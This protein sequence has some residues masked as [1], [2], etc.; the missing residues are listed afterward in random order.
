MG[1]WIKGVDMSIYVEDLS[2]VYLSNI[3][4][5]NVKDYIKNF[6]IKKRVQAV[7]NLNFKIAQGE[8][9]GFIGPNGAGKSTTIKM[10]S[11]ILVPTSGKIVINGLIPFKDRKKYVKDIGVVFGQRSQ[12]WWDIPAIDSFELLKSIYKVDMKEYKSN[13]ETLGELLNISEIMYKPVRQL[14]LGQRM[15]CEVVASFLHSPKVVYLDEPTI[16]LDVVAKDQ[17]RKYIKKINDEKKT[18]V[19]LTTHDLSDIEDLCSRV[20]IIDFGQIIFDGKTSDIKNLYGSQKVIDAYFKD[21]VS[22][23]IEGINMIVDK[24]NYKKFSFMTDMV[25]IQNVIEALSSTDLLV[26]LEIMDTPIEEIIKKVYSQRKFADI[27]N[28]V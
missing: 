1:C 3:V 12:L 17:I 6:F 16:G 27:V 23:D 9:V 2:K 28:K 26:D 4:S 21:E 22:L 11:G 5:H 10:L 25:E 8:I 7:N 13:I 15:R 19:I 18:T 24:G 14:S 20:I